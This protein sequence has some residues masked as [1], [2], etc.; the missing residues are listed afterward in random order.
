MAETMDL[1]RRLMDALSKHELDAML[2]LSHPSVEWHSFFAALGHGS[3]GVYRG[4]EGT[5]QYVRDL[6]DAWDAVWAEVDDGVAVGEVAL[7]VGRIHFRGKESGVETESATGWVLR[8]SGGKL[9]RF[10]AFRD[11]DQAIA[12][13]GERLEPS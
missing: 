4:H 5:R 6:D 3:D 2:D 7:L 1:A 11:P 8:F 10:D 12:G 9:I 13:L